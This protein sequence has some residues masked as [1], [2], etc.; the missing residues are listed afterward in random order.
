MS[1]R[2]KNPRA[3]SPSRVRPIPLLSVTRLAGRGAS[4]GSSL[5]LSRHPGRLPAVAGTTTGILVGCTIVAT[6]FV[7]YQTTPV[8]LAFLRYLVGC[9]CLLPLLLR[10]PRPRFERRDLV[11]ICALGITQFGVLVVLLNQ[12]LRYI[13]SARAALIFA[14][15]PLLTMLLASALKLEALTPAKTLGVLLAIVA[16]GIALGDQ[17]LRSGGGT[18]TWIG[19]LAAFGSALSGAVCSVFYRPYLRKYPTLSISATAMLASVCF[20]AILAGTEGLF[21]TPPRFTLAGWLVVLFI[22]VSSGLGY[23]LWLWALA[24][25]TPTRVTLFIALSPVTAAAA[26]AILLGE[27]VAPSTGLGLLGVVLGLWLAHA[28][29]A[30][31]P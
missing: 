10:A 17:A 3:A 9:C 21:A 11:P 26:G 16:V 25:A 31:D 23:A 28:R 20:L 15:M 12:A 24:H 7:V 2:A 13:P 27:P 5:A 19:D 4:H 29:S 1:H 18:D 22:G 6:R 30:G 8:T 14:T